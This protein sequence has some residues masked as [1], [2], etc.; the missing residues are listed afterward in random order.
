MKK[1]NINYKKSDVYLVRTFRPGLS[2]VDPT[3]NAKFA[4]LKAAEA[5][6]SLRTLFPGK[7]GSN[8]NADNFHKT[9]MLM[10]DIDS[11]EFLD[12]VVTMKVP[13]YLDE[14]ETVPN[15]EGL[16]ALD[17]AEDA[18][19]LINALVPT[20]D[21]R[22]GLDTLH[23]KDFTEA[24]KKQLKSLKAGREKSTIHKKNSEVYGT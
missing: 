3:K 17:K 2:V 21:T 11:P 23:G 14:E 22:V 15:T 1:L 24:Q 18:I 8:E 10:K 5:D 12:E 9:L 20:G 19:Y 6:G 7:E 16:I 4:K 13:D